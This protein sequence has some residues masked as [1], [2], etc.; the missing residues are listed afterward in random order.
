MSLVARIIRHEGWKP[1]IYDDA[2]GERVVPGYTMVGNATFGYGFTSINKPQ[3]APM[4]EAKIAEAT[5]DARALFKG[6][7]ALD[8]IRQEALIEMVYQLG[9]TRLAGFVRMIAA[10]AV[11]DWQRA[12]AEAK[13]SR[14]ARQTPERAE[15]VA[16]MLLTGQPP[17]KG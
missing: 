16:Q 7:D 15:E 2:N 4:L 17:A 5:V 13:D 8:R 1:F 12:Y 10:V 6:F 14:W 9:A 11:R 3:A